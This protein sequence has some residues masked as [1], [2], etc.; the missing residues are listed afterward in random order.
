MPFHSAIR[1]N[2][3][4]QGNSEHFTF[5]S[6]SSLVGELNIQRHNVTPNSQ[7]DSHLFAIIKLYSMQT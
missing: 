4:T 2:L 5:L 7:E 3:L 6:F 1:T